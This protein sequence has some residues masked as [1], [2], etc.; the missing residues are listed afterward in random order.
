MNYNSVSPAEIVGT[1]LIATSIATV[2]ALVVDKWY[3]R[4]HNRL[5]PPGGE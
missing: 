4:K 3:Q 2:A 1:T 5:H